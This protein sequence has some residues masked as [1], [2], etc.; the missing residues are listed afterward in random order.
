MFFRRAL[1]LRSYFI[2][3]DGLQ[4]RLRVSGRFHD[5]CLLELFAE[6]L[7]LSAKKARACFQGLQLQDPGQLFLLTFLIPCMLSSLP[8]AISAQS[9]YKSLKIEAAFTW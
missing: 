9:V 3:V 5:A 7:K 4:T 1:L 6:R 2:G 8:L